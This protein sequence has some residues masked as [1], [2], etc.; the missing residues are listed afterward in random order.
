MTRH[1]VPLPFHPSSAQCKAMFLGQ[2][3]AILAIFTIG[4]AII[5]GAF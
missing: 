4:G 5:K 1:K 3:F 2:R